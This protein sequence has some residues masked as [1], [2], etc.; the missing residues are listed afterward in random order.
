MA[1]QLELRRKLH[2]IMYSNANDSD[3]SDLSRVGCCIDERLREINCLENGHARDLI[4]MPMHKF[5]TALLRCAN[6]G[7]VVDNGGNSF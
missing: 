1:T 5:R 3:D 2:E 6:I 4:V 7:L